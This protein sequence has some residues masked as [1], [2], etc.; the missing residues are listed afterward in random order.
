MDLIQIP[1]CENPV[2]LA[3]LVEEAACFPNV[4]F[5]THSRPF[6]LSSWLHLETPWKQAPP[7]GGHV[8]EG[9]S[10]GV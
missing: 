7:P 8:C 3:P 9:V 1:E 2:F 4:C 5:Q 6:S 10:K